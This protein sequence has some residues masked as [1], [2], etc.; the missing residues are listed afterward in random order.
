MTELSTPYNLLT[1]LGDPEDGNGPYRIFRSM[2]FPE[3]TVTSYVVTHRHE[4]PYE[5]MG[6]FKYSSWLHQTGQMQSNEGFMQAISDDVWPHYSATM[7]VTPITDGGQWVD[8]TLSVVRLTMLRKKNAP[9]K[10][11]GFYPEH[12]YEWLELTDDQVNALPALEAIKVLR[13]LLCMPDI[14]PGPTQGT[15]ETHHAEQNVW[16]DQ[17]NA[18]VDIEKKH[19]LSSLYAPTLRKL[20][21]VLEYHARCA[22]HPKS[23]VG[24]A[25][26]VRIELRVGSLRFFRWSTRPAEAMADILVEMCRHYGDDHGY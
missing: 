16:D 3:D 17:F 23:K 2:L 19:H 20:A 11:P 1:K 6:L 5:T 26:R 12:K 15:V 8:G 22:G 14:G 18:F 9:P 4:S 21:A 10:E 24:G 25:N 13:S 7:Q